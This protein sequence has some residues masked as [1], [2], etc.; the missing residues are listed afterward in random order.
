MP[1]LDVNFLSDNPTD[2][3]LFLQLVYG[4]CGEINNL[5]E[6]NCMSFVCSS[7]IPFPY[8]RK[9]AKLLVE[10]LNLPIPIERI[11]DWV[12]WHRKNKFWVLSQKMM[13]E[14]TRISELNREVLS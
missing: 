5:R 2:E 12:D 10:K 6:E 11:D 4:L 8:V 1:S 7:G 14:H 13:D 9:L 3:Q